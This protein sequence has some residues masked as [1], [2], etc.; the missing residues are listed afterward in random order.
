MIG[1]VGVDRCGAVHEVRHGGN[2]E[3]IVVGIAVV[4][5]H[6]DVDR[7]ACRRRRRIGDR[8]GGVI[9]GRLAF[10][11]GGDV[12]VA[13]ALG[14][15][16]SACA[17]AEA[18]VGEVRAAEELGSDVAGERRSHRLAIEGVAQR[19][20]C[21]IPGDDDGMPRAVLDIGQGHRRGGEGAVGVRG[22]RC[23]RRRC[24]SQA[25]RRSGP[26]RCCRRC[27][28]RSRARSGYR[29]PPSRC[30]RTPMALAPR[31]SL[32]NTM[33]AP[34]APASLAP[35]LTSKA[36]VKSWRTS[37]R[38][39]DIAV[40]ACRCLPS[41][42][43]RRCSRR[44]RSRAASARTWGESLDW[45]YKQSSNRISAEVRNVHV[46]VGSLAKGDGGSLACCIKTSHRCDC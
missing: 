23:G 17:G 45:L 6:G 32:W 10:E 4:G 34:S 15:V 37:M 9:A 5:E 44:S 20:R 27:R 8:D 16:Q 36:T 29:R 33:A 31:G 26:R 22:N 12:D 24:R 14:V 43:C 30:R 13:D 21:R 38:C 35:R 46:P 18:E 11:G 42:G 19:L 7:S 25:C 3:R 40:P 39:V 28:T 1:V 41:S 2:G